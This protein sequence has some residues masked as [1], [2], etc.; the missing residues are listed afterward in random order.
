MIPITP[1]SGQKIEVDLVSRPRE[2]V[3]PADYLVMLAPQQLTARSSWP[4]A[5]VLI[6]VQY[7]LLE[8]DLLLRLVEVDMKVFSM[9]LHV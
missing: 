1:S 9:N 4:T 5:L 7:L 6:E 3:V 2:K 8:L